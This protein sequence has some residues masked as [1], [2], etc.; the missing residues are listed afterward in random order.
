[1]AWTLRGTPLLLQTRTKVL[2]N[3]LEEVFRRWYPRFEPKQRNPRLLLDSRH[4][5]LGG[6]SPDTRHSPAQIRKRKKRRTLLLTSCYLQ[7]LPMSHQKTSARQLV[8]DRPEQGA[9]PVPQDLNPDADQDERRET[10]DNVHRRFTERTP[11][12]FGEPVA[13]IYGS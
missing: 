2:N 11:D 10:N 4:N 12:P 5:D 9:K 7:V 1:M 3:E 8:N 6:F 13:E